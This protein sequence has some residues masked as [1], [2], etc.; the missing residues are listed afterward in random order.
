MPGSASSCGHSAWCTASVIS[1]SSPEY[2]A[3]LVDVDLRERDLV[4]ALAA[5][6]FV[7]QALA[8]EVA[9]GELF[10]AVRQVRFEHVALQQRVV[11]GSR[12]R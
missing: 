6:V 9:L 12:A 10:Q 7:A 5:Q 1:L 3:A 2:S 8:A 4:R 11:R